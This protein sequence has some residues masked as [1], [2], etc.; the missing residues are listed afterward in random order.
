MNSIYE[1]NRQYKLNNQYFDNINTEEKAYWLG[2][3]W[4]DGSIHK[5]N[6]R[7]K[8]QNRLTIVQKKS[9]IKHIQKFNKAISSSEPALS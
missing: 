1:I 9:E 8:H 4:A 5:T 3:L 6:P 7:S 2:F